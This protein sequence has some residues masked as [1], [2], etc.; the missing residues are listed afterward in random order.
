M[1][2]S[3]IIGSMDDPTTRQRKMEKQNEETGYNGW[4]NYETWAVNLWVDNE[5]WSYLYWREQAARHRLQA[6]DSYQVREG[7]WTKEEATR[8]NLADQLLEEITDA[9]PLQEASMYSDLLSGA[10]AEVNWVEIADHWLS[11]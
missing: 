11:E 5:Q 7:L 4:T 3:A 8:F 9:S 2:Y 6:E 10:L 1:P